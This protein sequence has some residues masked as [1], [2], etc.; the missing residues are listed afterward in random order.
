MIWESEIT[1]R[2]GL[3][4]LSAALALGLTA[5]GGSDEADGP[6][7]YEF[8]I[9][10]DDITSGDPKAPVTVVEYASL[11][12]PHCAAF[13]NGIFPEVKT[14]LIDTGK[15]FFVQRPFPRDPIDTRGWLLTQCIGEERAK[16]LLDLMF[17]S[18][19]VWL[20]SNNPME[21]LYAM[22]SNTG[23]SKGEV[24]ACFDNEEAR[25]WLQAKAG[26][27]ETKYGVDSTPTFFVNGIKVEGIMRIADFE[28]MLSESEGAN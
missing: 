17:S 9:T 7:K 13:H 20:N 23:M 24:D 18:Q 14:K 4:A 19:D 5:C 22:L 12:C 2:A 8:T 6:P 16:P 15:V 11:T 27:A 3:L 21:N 26:D 28:R 10:E 25:S 1:R